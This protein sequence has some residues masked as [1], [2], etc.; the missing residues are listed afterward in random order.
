MSQIKSEVFKNSTRAVV[1]VHRTG[2]L[3]DARYFRKSVITNR[4]RGSA[5]LRTRWFCVGNNVLPDDWI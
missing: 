3:S 2:F 5:C 1:S 4:K